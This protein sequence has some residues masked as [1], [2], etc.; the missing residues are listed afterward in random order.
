M[1]RIIPITGKH[2][3][4]ITM[5][6]IQHVF[7][8]VSTIEPTA[9]YYKFAPNAEGMKI[10]ASSIRRGYLRLWS[11]KHINLPVITRH[12]DTAY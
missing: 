10:I 9:F 7:P 4:R 6:I 2:D 3:I 12:S 1:V 8:L 11:K 5:R